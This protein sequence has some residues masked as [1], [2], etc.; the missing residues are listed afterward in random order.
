MSARSVAVL[1]REMNVCKAGT[2]DSTSYKVVITF[3]DPFEVWSAPAWLGERMAQD[4]PQLEVLHLPDGNH[5]GQEVADTDV[6]IAW[7]LDPEQLAQATR[8]KWIHVP[9]AGVNQFMRPDLTN[10][11]I[12]ITNSSDVHA[13]LVAEHA[14]SCMLALAKRIPQCL[15]CQSDKKWDQQKLWDV[16][17]RPREVSGATVLVIGMGSI[18]REFTLRAKALGMRVLA[19][20][21]NPKRGADGA[22]AIY[23]PEQLEDLLPQA[24]F[25][26]LCAPL[27]PATIGLMNRGRLAKMKR[28][29]YL[30]NVGRGELIE[31]SALIEALQ[32]HRIGGA[33]LD[34]FN[35]EP[36]PS[37]SPFWPLDNLLI[38]PHLA[39][40]IET[41]WER[42]YDLIF[43]NMT[44]FFDGR[45]LLNQVDKQLGY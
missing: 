14:L 12:V 25:V 44:R 9:A 34:V 15:R 3:S 29:A 23:G 8:L 24:D 27:T 18:G 16:H 22:D 41:I 31:D 39:A 2:A 26:L 4:F 17:P 33:A 36:L 10:S 37:E 5:L 11:N 42:H 7:T 13:P 38:T 19:I 35:Q 1:E 21:Q 30:I 28:S 6:L 43:E 45:P 40:A 20:R 32:N